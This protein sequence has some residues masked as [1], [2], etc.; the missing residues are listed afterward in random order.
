MLDVSKLI[1]AKETRQEDWQKK[2][3]E[4]RVF[5]S[6]LR[7][8]GFEAVTDNPQKYTEYLTLQ[9]DNPSYSVGN[10]V[11]CMFQL[12]EATLLGTR[13][14]WHNVGR[15][16]LQEEMERGAKIYSRPED[17]KRLGYEIVNCYDIS[18]TGGKPMKGPVRLVND[19]PQ[20]EMAVARLLN[21]CPTTATIVQDL[22]LPVAAYYN[23]RDRTLAINSKDFQD[24]EVFAAV[25]AEI[26]FAR[27]HQT[28]NGVT[29]DRG[30]YQLFADS[31]SYLLCQRFGVEGPK[32]DFS[33]IGDICNGLEAADR[34]EMLEVIYELPKKM[35]N[36]IENGIAPPQKEQGYKGFRTR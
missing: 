24:N 33:S 28:I 6:D 35:G 11:V 23:D 26:T 7:D 4:D 20:M 34:G 36:A 9:A 12:P 19:S 14:R 31:T 30:A 32:R 1:Q 8:A 21:Y 22:E 29:F 15:Y 25:T 5:L 10:V 3:Q 13:K 16:V 17:K 2:R 18:Q 27:Y